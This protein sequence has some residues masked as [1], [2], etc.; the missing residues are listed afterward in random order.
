MD[1][2][3]EFPSWEFDW[4]KGKTPSASPYEYLVISVASL[5]IWKW[6]EVEVSIEKEL[7]KTMP[8]N[9]LNPFVWLLTSPPE[10]PVT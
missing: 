3:K 8:K 5:C 1:S 6:F 4:S 9:K 7:H 2:T 10:V